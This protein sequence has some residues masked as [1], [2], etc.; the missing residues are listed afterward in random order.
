[1]FSKE[2]IIPEGV[3]VEI[4]GNKI[5]V[6]GQKGQIEKKLETS[7]EIKIEK[8]E[9]KIK[10]SSESEKRMVK[11]L[12]GTIIAHIRNA[13]EGVVNGYVYKLKV[14]F[15]HFPITVKVEG[16][17]VLIQNFLGER[18]PR[19]AKIVGKTEVKVDGQDITVSG[20]DIDDVS[21]TSA[22]IEQATRRTGYDKKVFQDGCYIISKGE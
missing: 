14:V 11:A 8:L 16:D 2:L 7:R 10:V 19:V 22:N 20:I 12:V 5:K 18:I 9:K 21:R 3:T 4:E 1:M 13:I 6:S 17:K 15:S